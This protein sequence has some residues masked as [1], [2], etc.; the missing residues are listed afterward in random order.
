[1]K[2]DAVLLAWRDWN[3]YRL[4]RVDTETNLALCRDIG[5]LFGK[6]KFLYE[7]AGLTNLPRASTKFSR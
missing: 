4:D 2:I 5:H 3:K 7:V 1:M 6:Q